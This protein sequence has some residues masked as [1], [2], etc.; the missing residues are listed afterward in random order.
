MRKSA[1]ELSHMISIMKKR[2]ISE[3]KDKMIEFQIKLHVLFLR[4]EQKILLRFQNPINERA[5]VF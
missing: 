2:I 3:D 5:P 4:D 1:L